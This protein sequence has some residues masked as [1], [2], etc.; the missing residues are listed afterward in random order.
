MLRKKQPK[1]NPWKEYGTPFLLSFAF[2][3]GLFLTIRLPNKEI[4]LPDNIAIILSPHFDD[5]ALSLGGFMAENNSPVVVI[6]FFGGKPA[7]TLQ[8]S[9]D[10][11]SGFK[12]SA[13]AVTQRTEE[14]ARALAK[15][16][17]YPLNL[18]YVDFQY[19]RERDEAA[20]ENLTALIEKDI[21]TIIENFSDTKTLSIYGPAEFGPDITHTD[22]K[23]LH[24]AFVKIA[25]E[26]TA[27]KN[28]RFFFY[29]DFPYVARYQGSA[30][31][32]LQDFLEKNSGLKLL[33][34]SLSVSTTTLDTKIKAINAYTSQEK[35]F[36][37]LGANIAREAKNFTG[38]R[39][40]KPGKTPYACE[41]VYEITQ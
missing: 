26:K 18:N 17:A 20:E 23:T 9:W 38:N 33:K 12:D 41:V 40:K 22:H 19:R 37:A 24:E 30:T 2:V 34:L 6:T 21:G 16:K 7:E 4:N 29:E 39:C 27:Q 15:A 14:N 13:E 5:A 11:L 10:I 1:N 3:G 31:N 8:G 35:A 28:L 25:R 36:E 32:S